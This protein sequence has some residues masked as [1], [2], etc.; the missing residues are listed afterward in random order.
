MVKQIETGTYFIILDAKNIYF[1]LY[2][3]NARVEIDVI[4]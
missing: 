1:V 2:L 3:D 4:K